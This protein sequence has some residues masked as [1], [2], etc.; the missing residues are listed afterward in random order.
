MN[1]KKHIKPV[2]NPMLTKDPAKIC[3][4]VICKNESK[5]IERMLNSVL[6][7]LDYYVIVDTGS[8]DGT[9]EIIE[10]FFRGKMKIFLLFLH[11]L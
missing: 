9:Q 1:K 10:N 4:T 2:A 5:V 3:L 6:P 7:I 8:T 11:L